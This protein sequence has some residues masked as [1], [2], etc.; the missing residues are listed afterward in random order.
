VD[1]AILAGICN[2]L[3]D[4]QERRSRLLLL[5]ETSGVPLLDRGAARYRLDEEEQRGERCRLA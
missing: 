5:D 2:G 4:E 3:D 1:P